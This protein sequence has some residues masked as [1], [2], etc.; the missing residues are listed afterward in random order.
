LPIQRLLDRSLNQELNSL[1][2]LIRDAL[3]VH[4]YLLSTRPSYRMDEN[5]ITTIEAL[6]KQLQAFKIICNEIT[7]DSLR[8]HIGARDTSCASQKLL[9]TFIRKFG[10]LP[11][12]IRSRNISLAQ[13]KIAKILIKL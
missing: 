8:V 12:D 9:D 11:L 7:I 10:V 6:F 3:V 5:L 2:G 13:P 4:D 1:S